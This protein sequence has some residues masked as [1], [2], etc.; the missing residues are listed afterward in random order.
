MDIVLQYIITYVPVLV[1]F[2]AECGLIKWAVSAIR[3]AKDTAEFKKL[4]EREEALIRELEEARKQ[5]KELLTK[6]DRIAR[7]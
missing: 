2:I 5:N 4:L 7:N 6:I 1:A 3:K